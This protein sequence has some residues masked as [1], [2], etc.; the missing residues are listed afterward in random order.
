MVINVR[1]SLIQAKNIITVVKY[2]V[3]LIV[4]LVLQNE[5]DAKL[6]FATHA[7]QKRS[8]CNNEANKSF[9][10]RSC[11]FCVALRYVKKTC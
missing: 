6:R 11:S 4:C 10:K 9:T 8:F 1:K 5:V 2:D 3:L 7:L